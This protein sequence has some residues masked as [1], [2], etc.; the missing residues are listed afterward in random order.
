MEAK[1]YERIY[2]AHFY[3]SSS[4]CIYLLL[5]LKINRKKFI[6][7]IKR[8]LK[9][10]KNED[11]IKTEIEDIK[12]DYED[13][14]KVLIDKERVMKR[15]LNE[16]DSYKQELNMTYKSLLAKSTELEYMNTL[17]EKK[18]ANLSNLNAVGRSVVSELD[19]ERIIS[20]ILDAFFVLTGAKKIALYLWEDGMLINKAFKGNIEVS[21]KE[22]NNYENIKGIRNSIYEKQYIE[23][24]SKLKDYEEGVIIT[25][26]K[27]KGKEL[28]AIFIIEDLKDGKIKE[29]EMETISA[30]SLHAAIAINN[31]KMYGELLEKERIEKR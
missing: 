9:S 1:I 31:A 15:N 4:G 19:L 29:D 11:Y 18:V 17:L 23:I 26:L 22:K 5:L 25:E 20:I 2:G 8:I 3:Y 27:V 10:I 14:V 24:A 21:G 7:E 12:K 6:Y 28:G 16:L 13:V 30:L